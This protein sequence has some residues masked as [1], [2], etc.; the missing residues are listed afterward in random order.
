MKQLATILLRCAKTILLIT[1]T[2]VSMLHA[3][4]FPYAGEVVTIEDLNHQVKRVRLH[5]QSGSDFS[6]NP[7]QFLFVKI[8][9]DYVTKWNKRYSTN[10]GTVARPYSIASAPH[11]LPYLDL[12]I[13]HQL[14]PP[15]EIVPPGLASTYIHTKLKVGDPLIFSAPEGSLVTVHDSNAI[16]DNDPLILIAGG[17]GLAP[18]LSVLEYCFKMNQPRP[19]YLYLGVKSTRDLLLDETLSGWDKT[20]TNFQYIPTLSRPAEDDAWRGRTGYVNT[21]LASD[22]NHP[23]VADVAIAGP[24]IMIQETIKVLQAKGLPQHRIRYDAAPTH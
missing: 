4:Q 10:H 11:R 8:P 1:G 6:F 22:F 3:A 16:T 5:I 19:I 18:F 17:T 14:S 13:G 24:P 23:L 12:I 21:I 2:G 20:R 15:G 9:D 7:G